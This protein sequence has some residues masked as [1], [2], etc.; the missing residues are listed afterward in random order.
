MFEMGCVTSGCFP[1][2]GQQEAQTEPPALSREAGGVGRVRPP[3]PVS[4]GDLC[5]APQAPAGGSVE[6]SG[7]DAGGGGWSCGRGLG[8]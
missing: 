3:S 8:L 7:R 2:I 1:H 6:G 4:R 5:Q